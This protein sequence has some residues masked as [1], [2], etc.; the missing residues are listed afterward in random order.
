MSMYDPTATCNYSGELS[1]LKQEGH[2]FE[3]YQSEFIRL[4]RLV[5]GL[6][7]EFLINCFV[8]RLRDP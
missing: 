3:E 4:S 2:N 8:S 1:K 6:C 7:E 5:H